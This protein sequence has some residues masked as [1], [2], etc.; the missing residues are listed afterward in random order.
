MV[1]GIACVPRLRQ[2]A[3]R[4]RITPA[5]VL[6][7][8]PGRSDLRPL[9][10]H[11]GRGQQLGVEPGIQGN[12]PADRAR[13]PSTSSGM[14]DPARFAPPGALAGARAVESVLFGIQ[15]ADPFTFATT[16]ALLAA[17]GA[18]A[19]FLLARRASR[20]DPSQVLRNE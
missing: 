17:I 20:L 12:R 11:V 1:A 10:A 2:S 14:D 3:G 9:P 13:R 5:G 7:P 18:A 16:A 15:P 4:P 19:A 6:Q 8:R